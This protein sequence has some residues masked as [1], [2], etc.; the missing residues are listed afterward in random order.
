[1]LTGCLLAL[2]EAAVRIPQEVALI[3]FDDPVWALPVPT[4]P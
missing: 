2:K 3:G 1:M 4:R